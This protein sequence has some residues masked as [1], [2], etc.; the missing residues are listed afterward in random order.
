M[1]PGRT[2]HQRYFYLDI[3]GTPLPFQ[4]SATILDVLRTGEVVEQRL[5]NR[6]VAHNLKLIL[7]YRGCLF[8]A[9]FRVVDV[10]EREKTGSKRIVLNY[11]DFWGFE[12]AAY[13]LN[14][15]L[16]IGRIPLVVERTIGGA[17]GSVQISM[18][19]TKPE[20]LL[21]EEGELD[22]PDRTYWWQPLAK[23]VQ[24]GLVA[25]PKECAYSYV[26]YRVSNKKL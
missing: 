11:R 26:V 5:M 24:I 18:E 16:G 12:I 15:V 6:G 20:D 14:E 10:T 2:G 4:D 3:D 22:R 1:G 21:L 17:P 25:H 9:V 13:A 19:G 8:H 7:E 23:G